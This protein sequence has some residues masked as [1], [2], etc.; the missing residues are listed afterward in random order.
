[1]KQLKVVQITETFATGVYTYLKDLSDVLDEIEGID[2][3]IIYSGKRKGTPQ[4]T[5]TKS[6]RLIQLYMSNEISIIKDIKSSFN[7]YRLLLGINPDIIHVHSSKAGFIGRLVSIFLGKNLKILYTPHGFSFLRKDIPKTKQKLFFFIE[8]FISLI[9]KSTIIACGDTELEYAKKLSKRVYLIRNGI[10]FNGLPTYMDHAPNDRLTIGILSRITYA[11][12]PEFFNQI[13][14]EFPEFDFLWIGDG[15]LRNEITAPNIKV[16]GWFT[17]KQDGYDNLKRLDIYL[18][19]SLWEGLPISV[20]EAMALRKPVI[21]SNVIGNKDAV[22][23]GVTGFL[24][25]DFS[26]ACSYLKMLANDKDLRLS[27]GKEGYELSKLK[28]DVN[29]NFRKLADYYFESLEPG[30]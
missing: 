23:H 21:A 14:L 26:E 22:K 24:Y 16:T 8:R 12:N 2:N 20:L 15:E 27:L 3:T 25:N 17:E 10:N 29:E 30:K 18:Q 28:F 9:S 1:M 11:R 5:I 6:T 19:T 4:N 13:A 7:L